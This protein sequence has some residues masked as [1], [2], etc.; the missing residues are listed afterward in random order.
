MVPSLRKLLLDPK[1]KKVGVISYRDKDKLQRDFGIEFNFDVGAVDLQ[2][3][4]DAYEYGTQMGLRSMAEKFLGFSIN[5]DQ[6]LTDW[7]R[8]NLNEDEILYAATD[9]WVGLEIYKAIRA[10]LLLQAS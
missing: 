9:A 2:R 5:K 7:E 6:T 10:N 3:L 1:I 4:A 8:P